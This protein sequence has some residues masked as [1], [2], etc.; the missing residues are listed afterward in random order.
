MSEDIVTPAQA[1]ATT[2]VVPATET[3]APATTPEQT[4]QPEGE[5]PNAE[6]GEDTPRGADG[7]F[8]K[9]TEKLQNQIDALVAQKRQEER[10][11]QILRAQAE[12]LKK[13]MSAPVEIDPVDFDAQTR[14]NVKQ[15][16][17]EE[18]LEQTERAA[19]MAAQRAKVAQAEIFNAQVSE[20][21]DHIPDI[22]L[23]FTPAE[24]GGPTISPIMAEAIYRADNS[25]LVAYHLAKNPREATRIANMD[26]VSA[27]VAIGQIAAGIKPATMK[28]ISQAPAPV[29]TV[30][31]SNAS[32]G[33]DLS[34]ASYKDYEAMRLK[35]MESRS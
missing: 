2:A 31:G 10:N 33:V 4:A 13:R 9:R 6:N 11:V 27:L 17:S 18:K 22:D 32:P 16:L 15:V 25:A 12:D 30:S 3:A 1:D 5:Q 8:V 7:R 24:K 21:R 29:P 28:R 26:P 35:Q 14:H 23:I 20:L 19:E 34:T